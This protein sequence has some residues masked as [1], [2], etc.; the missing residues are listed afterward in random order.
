[1]KCVICKKTHVITFTC[2]CEKVLCLKHRL[3]EDHK[4]DQE[5]PLFKV[6]TFIKDKIIKI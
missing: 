2:K 4:C 6:E 1:M 5:Q 3:P